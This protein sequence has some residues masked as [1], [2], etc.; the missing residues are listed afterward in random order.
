[1]YYKFSVVLWKVCA[2]EDFY[3]KVKILKKIFR[4]FLQ[5]KNFD[6]YV[7]VRQNGVFLASCG[8]MIKVSAAM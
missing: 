8:D 6:F 4:F 1:M 5:S 7:K 2:E 3:S